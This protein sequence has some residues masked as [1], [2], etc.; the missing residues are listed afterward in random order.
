MDQFIQDFAELFDEPDRFKPE[1]EFKKD[2]DWSSLTGISVIAMVDKKYGVTLKGRDIQK[3]LTLA[4][5]YRTVREKQ[6]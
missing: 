1:T 2:P 3:A 5:L 4:D 6:E